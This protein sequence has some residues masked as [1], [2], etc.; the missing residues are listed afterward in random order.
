[1]EPYK[2]KITV[3]FFVSILSTVSMIIGPKIMGKATTKLF[4]GLM[5]QISGKGNID[6]SYIGNIL[7]FTTGLYFISAIFSYIMGWIMTS[8]STDIT[9]RL[10]E[11][12][13]VKMNKIPL[14]YYDTTKHGQIL[15]RITNDIDTVNQTLSQS[16]TQ[17]ITSVFTVI[18]VMVMM[19]SINWLM[20]LTALFILPISM[21]LI[22]KVIK[23]SQKYFKQQQASLGNA[24]GHIE[25]MYGGHIVMKAFNG[26]EDSV[27]T[28][29][30]HNNSLYKSAWKSQFLS[31]LMM[32]ITMIVGNLGYVGISILGGYLVVK[33]T[34]NV[35]DIQAFIQYVRNFNQPI[36]QLANISNVLQQTAAA[37]ERVFEFMDEDQEIS[38]CEN[39]LKISD[40]KGKVEFKNIHFS[41]NP[42]NTCNKKFLSNC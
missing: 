1:M 41:Y 37:A 35:G 24:N 17:I 18:G 12:L 9:Y 5:L 20:T 32:P 16:L 8:V 6:F 31:G 3:V 39:P 29:E 11:D 2:A 34:I 27:K 30:E 42:G 13:S 23:Q 7:L 26:E 21:I 10:R 40:I 28:F 38:E 4:E 22:G 33:Q 15:S 25:E 19:F 14:S 36:G